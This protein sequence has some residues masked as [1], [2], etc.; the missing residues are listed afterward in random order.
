M[1]A[2]L[3]LLAAGIGGAAGADDPRPVTLVV[4]FAA[5]GPS[6]KL[7]RDLADALRRPLGLPIAIEN[8]AGAGGTLAATRVA[9]AAADG[10][11]LLLA[12]IGIATAPAL[13][14]GLQFRTL[15]DFDFLGMVAE[16]PMTLIGRPPCLHRIFRNC[17]SG[18]APTR[19][20]S[21]WPM[22]G[23]APHRTCAACCCSS[24]SAWP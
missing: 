20:A 2:A 10:H 23:R 6:D 16:V 4:P 14:R 15:E 5:G 17:S 18:C 24:A 1:A 3:V 21:T 9:K 7:A 22:R 19:G 11:T 12:H 13:Y 8:V